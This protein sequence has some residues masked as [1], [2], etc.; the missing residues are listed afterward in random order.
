M[1][2]ELKKILTTKK[3]ERDC[4]FFKNF[5]LNN[6]RIQKM[7]IEKLPLQKGDFPTPQIP[8]SEVKIKNAKKTE[9]KVFFFFLKKN[10]KKYT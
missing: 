4:N 1:T 8:P 3:A 5:Y 9:K 7:K 6:L 2:T 10:Y